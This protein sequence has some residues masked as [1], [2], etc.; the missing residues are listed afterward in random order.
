MKWFTNR[1][2]SSRH[3]V[4]S[5]CAIDSLEQ[6]ALLTSWAPP[7]G[8]ASVFLRNGDLIVENSQGTELTVEE[9]RIHAQPRS[10][11]TQATV[12]G[13]ANFSASLDDFT[14]DIIVDGYFFTAK[15]FTTP[16]RLIVQEDTRG[17]VQLDDMT[18]TGD[19]EV[20][21]QTE[22]SIADTRIHGSANIVASKAF[23]LSGLY[24]VTVGQDLIV[25]GTLGFER[26]RMSGGV[27]HGK[28]LI[29]TG[30][31]RDIVDVEGIQFEGPTTV[32]TGS[33]V[34]H[35]NSSDNEFAKRVVFNGSRQKDF[36]NSR[37]DSF[38]GF[39]YF[40]GGSGEDSFSIESPTVWGTDDFFSRFNILGEG[41]EDSYEMTDARFTEDRFSVSARRSVWEPQSEDEKQAIA[42]ANS[43]YSARG[44][45]PIHI[46]HVGGRSYQLTYPVR[47][48]R[49]FKTGRPKMLVNLETGYV[50]FQPGS[51]GRERPVEFNDLELEDGWWNDL[52][53]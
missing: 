4:P 23:F 16:G 10:H 25:S 24:R 28:T 40:K 1:K 19:L 17:F 51:G 45:I 47:A 35:I 53:S 37:D 42:L 32:H 15:G 31:G 8:D 48:E 11:F 38:S 14:G 50:D 13:G 6:R 46:Q 18:V 49:F 12:N 7:T 30:G 33:G 36:I 3:S 43:A 34:D 27:V 39:S 5:V 44:G 20:A 2:R 26:F 22:M 29:R 52:P 9:G 41:G 21:T